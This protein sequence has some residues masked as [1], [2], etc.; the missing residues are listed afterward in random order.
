MP[1][2]SA[3]AGTE[4]A[5]RASSLTE[6]LQRGFRW[7]RF[8]PALESAYRADQFRDGL[9]YLR[10]NLAMLAAIIVAIVQVDHLVMPAISAGVPDI[11]RLGVMVPILVIALALTFLRSAQVWYP[12][13]LS[14][15]VPLALMGIGWIGLWAWGQGEDRLFVR[16]IIAT[17]AVYFVLGLPF[18][19]A[20]VAN[21]AA[22]VFYAAAAASVSMPGIELTH[23]LAMLVMTSLICAAGAY[24]LEHARRTAWLEGQLLAET[25]L[26]DGLTGIHNRRRLDDHLQRVWQQCVREH[27]PLALLFADID[28]FKAYNDRYG[29]QA[30]DEALKTVAAVLARHARR[31]LDIAARFGGEEFAVVLFDT[32]REHAVRIGEEILEEVRQLGIAHAGSS[33]APVLTISLGIACVVPVARRSCAGLLQLADQALYSAKDGGRNQARLLEADYEH[34][35]TGYFRRHLPGGAADQ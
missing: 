19:S 14:A 34:M 15:L 16:L 17:V 1:G 2:T 9:K 23:Y 32:T 33:A 21:V 28:H 29:H 8:E 11:A 3:S 25:A 31:P 12:R 7:M 35:K 20:I 4:V 6:Q 5:D 26:Q 30:G 27:K 18:R 13:I 24:N 10:I 22:I